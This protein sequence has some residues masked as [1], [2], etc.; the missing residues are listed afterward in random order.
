[1]YLSTPAPIL[2]D[3][4]R[5]FLKPSPPNKPLLKSI[6]L[7]LEVVTSFTFDRLI[8]EISAKSYSAR[9]I[10]FN[11]APVCAYKCHLPFPNTA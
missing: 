8:D 10:T 6:W 2:I 7:I 9:K 5:L 4:K 11:A 3:K 1:M